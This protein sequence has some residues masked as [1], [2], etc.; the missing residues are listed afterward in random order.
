MT[1]VFTEAGKMVAVTAIE[2]GPCPV[3]TVGDKHIQLA[4]DPI[5]EKKLKKPV[6][7]FFKKLKISPCKIIREVQKAP[8]QECK[9]GDQ[10]KADIF[11]AGEFVDVIGTSIGKGFQGGVKR[12]GWSGGPQSHGSMSHRRIGSIGASASPSRV[13]KGHHLPGHMGAIRVTSQ[14]LRVIKVLPKDNLL[15][16]KGSVPGKENSYVIVRSA[17]KKRNIIKV[18]EASKGKDGSK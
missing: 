16:V 15:L 1:H 3:L 14:N 5:E 4:F 18:K 7:G 8:D 13:F 9:V 6:L 10:I 2:A 17:V 12:W 11:E